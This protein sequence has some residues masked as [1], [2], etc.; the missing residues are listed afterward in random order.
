M[1]VEAHIR[2]DG[3]TIQCSQPFSLIK[4][5]LCTQI[6]DPM[7][8]DN[9][10]SG[11]QIPLSS[12]TTLEGHGSEVFSCSWNP[13]LPLIASGSGDGTARI[14]KIPTSPCGKSSADEAIKSCIILDHHDPEVS[15]D[16]NH[17]TTL[18]WNREGDSIAT[19]SYDGVGRVWSA[20]GNLITTFKRHKGAIFSLKWSPNGQHILSGSLDKSALV[21]EAKTGQL[22]QQ[23]EFHKKATLDVDWKNNNTF[24]SCSSDTNI[25]VCEIGKTESVKMFRGHNDEVNAI[26]WDPQG[27]LLASCSD[28][29]TAKIW[30]MDSDRCLYDL[31]DHTKEIYTI[32]WSPTGTGTLNPNRN[33]YLATASFDGTVKLWDVEVGKCVHDLV[34]HNDQVYAVSFS[35]DGQFLA[36]GSIDK[37]LHIWSVQDGS[38]IKTFKGDGYVYDVSW[39]REGDKVAACFAS[40]TVCIVDFKM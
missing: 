14:W 15:T 7:N 31:T 35:P 4:P 17:V 25:F 27:K 10:V 3:T 21:W 8:I 40:Q 37:C 22:V 5:H 12:V 38:L 9:T 33:L 6:E 29:C 19:G 32:K 39:N 36:S 16:N 2:E 13:K 26:R 1:E 28:D 23:F 20:N 30:R 18:D 34:K 24:A 11:S